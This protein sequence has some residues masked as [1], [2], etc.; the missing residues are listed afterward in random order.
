LLKQWSNGSF[1]TVLRNVEYHFAK[2][3]AS[4]RAA[5]IDEYMRKAISAMN[6]RKGAGKAIEG[7]TEFVRRFN[8][9]GINRYV[10]FD[11]ARN[12]VVC[13]SALVKPGCYEIDGRRHHIEVVVGWFDV[14]TADLPFA[15]ITLKVT[16]NETHAFLAYPS[17][18]VKR[19]DGIEYTM[20]IGKTI[21][22]A[23]LDGVKATYNE[24][25]KVQ[26]LVGRQLTHDDFVWMCWTPFGAT[27]F[28]SD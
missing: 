12:L 6:E 26:E 9:H 20:G 17:V 1:R 3:G 18:F 7:A 14:S 19:P 11:T 13:W 28:S 15:K 10:D 21:D 5:N 22:E 24:I 2:H 4:V 8:V 16:Q 23:V 25:A 27:P